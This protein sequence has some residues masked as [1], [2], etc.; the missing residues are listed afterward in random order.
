MSRRF[1]EHTQVEI[2]NV[3]RFQASEKIWGAT[4]N[5]LKGIAI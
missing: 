5:A 2:D 3:R 4:A 1:L